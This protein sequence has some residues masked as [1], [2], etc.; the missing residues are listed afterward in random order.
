MVRHRHFGTDLRGPTTPSTESPPMTISTRLQLARRCQGS[1]TP[2]LYAANPVIGLFRQPTLT[3]IYVAP[4][5]IIGGLMET[6]GPTAVIWEP[7]GRPI[8]H[9]EYLLRRT[10]LLRCWVDKPALGST[11]VREEAEEPGCALSRV[12]WPSLWDRRLLLARALPPNHREAPAPSRAVQPLGGYNFHRVSPKGEPPASV[13][14]AVGGGG[15]GEGSLPAPVHEEL[16]VG[17]C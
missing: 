17:H 11:R 13:G 3:H 5:C 7:Q 16:D 8:R 6:I 2:A 14:E 1:P 9:P 10:P 15:V 4:L 12:P